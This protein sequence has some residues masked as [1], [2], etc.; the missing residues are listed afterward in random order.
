MEI[1]ARHRE[2]ETLAY[3]VINVRSPSKPFLQSSENPTKEEVERV[4]VPEDT[5]RTRMSIP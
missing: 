2:Y 5:N 1:T 3:S 4:Y